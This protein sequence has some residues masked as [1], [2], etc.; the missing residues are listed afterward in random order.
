MP[1]VAIE[2]RHPAGGVEDD[3]IRQNQRQTVVGIDVLRR[4][5][6]RLVEIDEP[7]GQEI[8]VLVELR[9]KRN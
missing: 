4:Q 2:L 3:W 6:V 7:A 5:R 9:G 1:I 8:A